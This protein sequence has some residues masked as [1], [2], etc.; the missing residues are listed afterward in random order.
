MKWKREFREQIISKY[1]ELSGET[2]N[3]KP[4]LII[5]PEASTPGFVL[6]DL[7]LMK[8]IVSMVRQ[9]QNFFL[10]GSA[11]YPKFTKTRHTKSGNT[12]LFFSP[13]GKVLGQYL[14]IRLLPFG[15]YVPYEEVFPW[16]EFLVPKGMKSNLAGTELNLF[17]LDGIR[18]GTLIC[19]EIMYPNLSRRMVKD[20]AGFL[21]NISNEAWFGKSAFPHQFLSICV[22]RAVENRINVIRCTN[23]GVSAFI[24]PCGRIAAKLTKEGKDIF[25]AGTLTQNILLSTP[26]AFYTLYGDILAYG[27]IAFSIGLMW[28]WLGKKSHGPRA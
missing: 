28:A 15:E 19:S 10:I 5:W 27:C 17:S 26:G 20:G 21:V 11:E 3:S 13:E 14:K 9:T 22:F 18:F 6:N 1:E 23:T 24:D 12:A 4:R 16:P 8:R 7:T 2:S 25:V